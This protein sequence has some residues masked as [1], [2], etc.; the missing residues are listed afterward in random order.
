[1]LSE[2]ESTAH[3][4]PE[5]ALA[6]AASDKLLFTP[7]EFYHLKKCACCLQRWT[8]F[9]SK[10]AV[11]NERELHGGAGPHY[12][13]AVALV[14]WYRT[15]AGF[16]ETCIENELFNRADPREAKWLQAFCE[17]SPSLIFLKDL[18]G[19]YI[20]V[21]KEFRRTLGVPGE[22]ILGK[23]DLEL[24]SIEEAM[25][26][27][28]NDRQVL[29]AGVPMEFEQVAIREDGAHRSVVHKFPLLNTNG[30]VSALGAIV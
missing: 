17:K 19:R 24:F 11:N 15:Q 26:F 22:G 27:Q 7:E 23:T 29:A 14:N 12:E 3:I 18:G 2:A 20:Y 5:R 10:Y 1:M 9:I 4:P 30:Q 8:E 28:A 25:V 21:N 13:G 16:L 6:I